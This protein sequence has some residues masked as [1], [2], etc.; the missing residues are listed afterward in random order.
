VTSLTFS[1]LFFSIPD[2]LSEEKILS[3]IRVI[4]NQNQGRKSLRIAKPVENKCRRKFTPFLLSSDFSGTAGAP[5]SPGADG[6]VGSTGAIGANGATTANAPALYTFSGGMGRVPTRLNAPVAETFTTPARSYIAPIGVEPPNRLGYSGNLSVDIPPADFCK[7][8]NLVVST[9]VTPPEN[10]ELTWTVVSN[11]S[12]TELSCTITSTSSSCSDT[13][14]NDITIAPTHGLI[15]EVAIRGG[16]GAPSADY[17]AAFAF[18]CRQV[19]S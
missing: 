19:L 8:N 6:A 5:G 12:A 7:L 1:C 17:S 13:T 14:L 3:C 16:T 4:K 11:G 2:A 9:S 18:T 10:T 15:V